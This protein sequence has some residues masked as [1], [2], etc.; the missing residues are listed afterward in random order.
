MTLRRLTVAALVIAFGSIETA[1]Q[2]VAT[3][4]TFDVASVKPNTSGNSGRMLSPLPGGR[5]V[6]TNVTL[7]QLIAFAFGVPN[8]HFEMIVIG[9]PDWIDADRFDVE[10]RVSTGDI[11][12]GQSGPL[13]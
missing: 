3:P 13:V 6:A 4:K 7:R 11:P 10:A 9:G 2:T 12:R 1:G 8:S 5:F